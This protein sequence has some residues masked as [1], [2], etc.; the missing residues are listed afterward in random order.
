[1]IFI[2]YF[3]E[4]ISYRHYQVVYITFVR[5]KVLSISGSPKKKQITM[6]IYFIISSGSSLLRAGKCLFPTKPMKKIG[7]FLDKGQMG[8]YIHMLDIYIYPRV[9]TYQSSGKPQMRVL[10]IQEKF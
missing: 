1:V 10:K 5:F 8:I 2:G 9:A 6:I 7:F 4:A 3:K